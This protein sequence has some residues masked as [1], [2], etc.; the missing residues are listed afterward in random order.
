MI[1]VFTNYI[2]SSPTDDTFWC[3]EHNVKAAVFRESNESEDNSFC[4]LEN[5]Y[6]I[7]NYSSWTE[8]EFS[9]FYTGDLIFS[10]VDEFRNQI[11]SIFLTK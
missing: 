3:A 6:K 5:N 4:W 7:K 2:C 10:G 11:V 8:Y 1:T 9:I